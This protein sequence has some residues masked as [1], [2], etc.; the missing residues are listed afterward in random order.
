MTTYSLDGVAPVL[1]ENDEYWIA[2]DA[3]V[4]GNVILQPRASLWF[5]VAA[6]GDNEPITVGEGSNV[7]EHTVMH[8]DVGVPLTLG[9]DVTVGHKAVLHGCA[10]G[11]NSLIG[12]G[13]IVLNRAVIGANC[14]VG[15]GALI[16]EGK[17]FEDGWLILGAPAKAVRPLTAAEIAGITASAQH[18]VENWRR[19]R[20]GLRLA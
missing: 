18:Y 9:R 14:L 5:G 11:D 17:V 10:V 19:Y 12:I 1:P 2:P 15:A 3:Q 13:A 8:T 16:T 6:R 4:I 20:R 7:Q